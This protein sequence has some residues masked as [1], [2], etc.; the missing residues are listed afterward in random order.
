MLDYKG[1]CKLQAGIINRQIDIIAV[2]LQVL[3]DS[4][5]IKVHEIKS[6]LESQLPKEERLS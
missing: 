2:L 4:G 6:F 1:M 5:V 3:V